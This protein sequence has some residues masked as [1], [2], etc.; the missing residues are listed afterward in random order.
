MPKGIKARRD[1]PTPLPDWVRISLGPPRTDGPPHEPDHSRHPK[2]TSSHAKQD[3]TK[4]SQPMTAS[5]CRYST[6]D[7]TA[8]SHPMT[9]G[10][11]DSMT[12]Y[13]SGA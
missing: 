9:F 4:G 3:A 5:S 2:K 1:Y 11:D 13:S 12:K 10:F 8:P 6:N 7:I